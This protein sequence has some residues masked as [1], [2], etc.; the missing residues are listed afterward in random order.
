MS[1]ISGTM[2]EAEVKAMLRERGILTTDFMTPSREELGDLRLRYPVAVKASSRSI[3][4]KTEVGGVFLDVATPK[5]LEARYD[6][7]STRF[8]EARVLV[9]SMERKGPEAIVG[10]FRDG[11]FG[12]S[13]MTGLGGVTAE[14]YKEVS[15][16][17]VPISRLDASEMVDETRLS[18]YFEGFR[19]F[20]ADREA[21]IDLLLKV[22]GW[23]SSTKEMEQ[24]DLNPVILREEGYVVVDAKMVLRSGE[25]GP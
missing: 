16:R 12:L 6:D 25:G 13:I 19:G 4:H 10:L 14:L 8:P 11:S 24:L 17:K 20:K 21:F 2:S 18:S 23:G 15:F 22:S 3:L 7:L 9:E 5:E 1:V